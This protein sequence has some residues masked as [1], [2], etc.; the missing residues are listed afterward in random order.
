MYVVG[1][2]KSKP[3]VNFDF[4]FF[5][6]SR[7]YTYP[8]FEYLVQPILSSVFSEMFFLQLYTE[9]RRFQNKS[10]TV[11]PFSITESKNITSLLR[12]SYYY[13]YVEA[14]I[15]YI[16]GK[17]LFINDHRAGKI[18]SVLVYSSKLNREIVFLSKYSIL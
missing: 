11:K 2:I 18:N 6:F 14:L 9:C 17:Q 13:Y 8:K 15:T 10:V 7:Y 16:A 4:F 12:I 5:F 3:D 1:S